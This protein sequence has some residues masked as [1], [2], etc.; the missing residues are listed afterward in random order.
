LAKS[1]LGTTASVPN[2]ALPV[3]IE[4]DSLPGIFA[5]PTALNSFLSPF[6][7]AMSAIAMLPYFIGTA[8]MLEIIIDDSRL[9]PGTLCH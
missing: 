6:A 2:F 9:N 3:A 8:I 5:F 1:I 7:P 4:W